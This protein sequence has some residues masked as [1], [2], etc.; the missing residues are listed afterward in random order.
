M[1]RIGWRMLAVV[2]A[3]M[4]AVAAPNIGVAQQKKLVLW[5]HWDQNPEFNKW[6][7]AKGKEFAKILK[8]SISWLAKAR[9]R[10]DGPPFINAGRS[11]R[12]FPLRKPE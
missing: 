8:I 9:K 11:I 6:Y 12:Y 2:T 10:G 5:T 4:I 1:K 7:E 3:A